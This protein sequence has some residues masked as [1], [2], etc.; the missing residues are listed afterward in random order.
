MIS[1]SSFICL[2]QWQEELGTIINLASVDSNPWVITA[3]EI[4]KEFPEDGSLNLNLENTQ[5][6]TYMDILTDLRK[7]GKFYFLLALKRQC[8]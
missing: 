3:A 2:F 8:V 5:N 7:A 1:M 4:V 6:K